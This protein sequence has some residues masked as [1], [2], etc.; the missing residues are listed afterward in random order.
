MLISKLRL[1]SQSVIHERRQLPS[2]TNVRNA[3]LKRRMFTVISSVGCIKTCY[4]VKFDRVQVQNLI[5]YALR[6]LYFHFKDNSK[7]NYQRLRC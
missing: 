5:I 4:K 7:I 6:K 3:G 2:Q 1:L